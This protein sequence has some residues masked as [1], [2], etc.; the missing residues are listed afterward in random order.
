[1]AKDHRDRDGADGGGADEPLRNAQQIPAL[2]R[3]AMV[4]NGIAIS[5]GTNS[6]PKV[7]LKNGAPTEIFSSRERLER[8][9]I[10]R[11]DEHRRAGAHQKEVVEH[12]R[13]FAR[14]RREQAPLLEQAARATRTAQSRRR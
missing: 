1:M 3:R 2:P 7:A 14:N 4:R 10:E 9:R 13:A 8:E 6:G 5:S 12:E 11:A